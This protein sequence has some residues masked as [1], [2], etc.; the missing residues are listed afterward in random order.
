MI[1]RDASQCGLLKLVGILQ[2]ALTIRVTKL[3]SKLATGL[4]KERGGCRTLNLLL[5]TARA[6]MDGLATASLRN[7]DLKRSET[8]RTVVPVAAD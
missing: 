2:Q 8:G 4:R 3:I 5:A 1:G 7:V 6:G